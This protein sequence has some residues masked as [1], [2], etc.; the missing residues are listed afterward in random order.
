MLNIKKL[1][2]DEDAVA[3]CTC[4]ATTVCSGVPTICSLIF[5][6]LCGIFFDCGKYAD[7]ILR[8]VFMK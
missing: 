5:D 7:W 1:L 8:G 6:N 3:T 4:C 2:K